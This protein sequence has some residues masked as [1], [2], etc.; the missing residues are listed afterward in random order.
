M[1][2]FRDILYKGRSIVI[3]R[4]FPIIYKNVHIGKRMRITNSIINYR[5]G[6]LTIDDDFFMNRN[7]S[8]NCHSSISIGKNCLLGE[9]VHIYDHNHVFMEINKPVAFQGFK[10]SAV[11]IGDNCWIGT[12]VT[13][14][15]GVEIGNNVIIGANCLIYHDIPSGS[16]VKSKQQLIIENRTDV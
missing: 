16:I 12:G 8:I 13:I 2:T 3:E 15:A 7:G 9:N 10:N 1:K 11:T 14:L 4:F 5:G 6:N